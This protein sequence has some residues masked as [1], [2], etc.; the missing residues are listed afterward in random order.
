MNFL[1]DTTNRSNEIEIMDDFSLKGEILKD[2]L[3]KLELTNRLLG[4]NKVT[5]LGLKKLTYS[6]KIAYSNRGPLPV[7]E[8]FKVLYFFFNIEEIFSFDFTANP[9]PNES[10]IK[11]ISISL[12]L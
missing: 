2:T 11:H 10:P 7:F 8:K 4:G 9:S 3:D 1:V 12:W 6:L 5:I